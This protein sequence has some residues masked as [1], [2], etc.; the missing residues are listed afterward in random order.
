[1]E[2]PKAHRGYS[3][4]IRA[5]CLIMSV[6]SM[7]F[8]GIERETDIYHTTVIDWVKQVGANFPD[9]Y[10][11]D[12]FTEVSELD[13]LQTLVGSK[14]KIWIWTAVNHFKPGILSWVIG[15]HSADT[16]KLL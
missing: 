2:K 7:G 10:D 5:M 6:N 3:D 14:Y 8:R 4:D 16:F 1:M 12:K 9:S 15:Y 11:P 13:R